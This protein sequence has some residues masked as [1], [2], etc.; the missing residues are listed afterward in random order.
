MT[1]ILTNVSALSALQTLRSISSNLDETQRM[2]SSGLRVGIAADNAAY[3]SISTTMHSD[4]MAMSAVSD[5]LGLGAAKVDTAY[6]GMSAVVDILSEFKAKL[7]AAAEDGVDRG[8]IQEELEQL[9]QQVVSVSQAASFSGE[10]WLQLNSS[11]TP[12]TASVVSAFVRSS[13]G[14]VSVATTDVDLGRI[15]LFNSNETGL[16]EA[17]PSLS[18]GDA[19]GFMGSEFQRNPYYGRIQI[20]GVTAPATFTAADSV[21]FKIVVDGSPGSAG[22]SYNI[23]INKTLIDSAL[24]R[25]DGTINNASELS[26]VLRAAF[27]Q[28]GVPAT[29]GQNSMINYIVSSL[30]TSGLPGSSII[31]QN[32]SSTLAG[33][34]TFGLGDSS[35]YV[36]DSQNPVP[37]GRTFGFTGPFSVSGEKLIFEYQALGLHKTVEIDKSIVNDAL[38]V[39]D[40]RINN[41]AEMKT[42]LEYAID[43]AGVGISVTNDSSSV[44]IEPDTVN[45]PYFGYKAKFGISNIHVS[46]FDLKYGLMNIDVVNGHGSIQDYISSTEIMLGRTT[47]ASSILGSIQSRIEMQL[48]F[49]AKLSDSLGRGIGRLVDAD[50]NEASTRLKAI[51]TQ[52]QLAIQSLS[53]ANQSADHVMQLFR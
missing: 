5:A 21:S 41:A 6:A 23:T 50:M 24:S 35:T 14:N 13:D 40:G 45:Y 26:T 8:K 32:V 20:N 44:T 39:T 47:S 48:D 3:W 11:P 19:G 49:T 38:G 9:K 18:I 30:E 46:G 43:L 31:L 25:F 12:Q 16:L 36:I 51:Q 17:E 29:A 33:G 10:N 4:R 53:I 34:Y 42:V 27:S 15:A 28:Q 37:S 52:Q 2:V 22:L 1:S 7:V